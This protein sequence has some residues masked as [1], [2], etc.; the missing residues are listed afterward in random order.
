MTLADLQYLI[1]AMLAGLLPAVGFGV[2]RSD[3]LRQSVMLFVS[4]GFLLALSWTRLDAPDIAIVEAV[5]GAGLTSVLLLSALGWVERESATM[6]RP[7]LAALVPVA[8]LSACLGAVV[9]TLSSPRVTLG[10]TVLSNLEQSGVTSAV[11]AVLLNFRAYDTLLEVSVLVAVAM[12]VSGLFPAGR[13]T[14]QRA[15]ITGPLL[16]PLVHWLLPLSVL[17]AGYLVWKGS[18][19]PGGAFQAGALVAAGGV[20][21]LLSRPSWPPH[22][23]ARLAPMALVSGLLCFLFLAAATLLWRNRLLEYPPNAA[24]ALILGVESTLT[25]SIAVALLLF[26]PR[27]LAADAS[28]NGSPTSGAG[29][30]DSPQ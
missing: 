23:V 10:A 14:S 19:G 29:G 30:W 2:V 24:K 8:A 27:P 7:P 3:D 1:D 17:A 26:F 25:V 16:A 22:G 20:L 15:E 5:V 12:A 21:L 11:T 13:A 6:S 9:F 18:R 4:F 28:A